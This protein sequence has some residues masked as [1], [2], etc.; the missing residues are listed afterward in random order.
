MT[1]NHLKTIASP[2]TW[3]VKR[4]TKVFV[5]RPNPGPHTL[6][7]SVPLSVF[8]RDLT[9]L[10]ETVKMARFVL[11]N[12][13]VFVNGTRR[14]DP[15]F[16]VGRFDV[17]TF[18]DTKDAY[19]ILLDNKGKLIA[20]KLTKTMKPN[21]VRSKSMIS[22]GRLQLNF[23]DGSNFITDKKDI[24]VGDSVVV[25]KGK[26]VQHLKLEKGAII[27]LAGGKYTGSVGTLEDVKESKIIYK[28]EDGEKV[29]TLKKYA[30]VI[31]K[32]KPVIELK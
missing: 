16:P 31:G 27:F 5:T 8:L 9:G 24:N 12:K 32:D 30:I 20:N 3:P 6:E 13:G 4:K 1:K 23:M 21:K 19:K 22:G 25:E 11:H 7:L 17:I 28:N 26:L 29:E 14:L 15:R 2:K 10:V 18:K